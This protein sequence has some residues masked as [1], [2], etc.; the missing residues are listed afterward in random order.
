MTFDFFSRTQL[1]V[2]SWWSD[3]SPYR[4]FFIDWNRF[5]AGCGEMTPEGYIKPDE[6]CLRDMFFR[7]PGLPILMARLPDGRLAGPSPARARR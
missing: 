7:K 1:K 6:A 4:D 3:A 5:W 2:L